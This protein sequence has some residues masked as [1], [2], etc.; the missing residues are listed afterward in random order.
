E[1]SALRAG[2]VRSPASNIMEEGDMRIK[3]KLFLGVAALALAAALTGGPAPAS[4]QQA[5]AGVTIGQS[6]LGGVV[7]SANGPEA[8]VWLIAETTDPPKKS[9]KI[10]VTDD[11]GRFLLPALPKGPYGVGGRGYGL[12]IPPRGQSEPGRV[13][14][15]TATTAPSAAAAAEYYPGVYWYS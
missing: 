13:P 3:G 11:K 6:D 2:S 8:G 1:T 7:T 9:A 5:P 14:T 10:V 15:L 4:A 12:V